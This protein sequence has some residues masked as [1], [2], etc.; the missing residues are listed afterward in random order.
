[1]F[2]MEEI[3][4]YSIRLSVSYGITVESLNEFRSFCL[5]ISDDAST[6]QISESSKIY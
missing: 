4:G 3:L 5:E 2:E 6:L 1:M